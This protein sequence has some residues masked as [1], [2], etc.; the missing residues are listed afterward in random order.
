VQSLLED[1]WIENAKVMGQYFKGKLEELVQRYDFIKEVRG[2]GLILG[3]ELEVPGAPVVDAC[4]RKGFLIICAHEKVL[5]FL[6]PLIIQKGEID[7]LVEALDGILGKL[8][9]DKEI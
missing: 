7:L 3:M 2:K 8:N 4:L 6:P 5:R 1:G 9:I